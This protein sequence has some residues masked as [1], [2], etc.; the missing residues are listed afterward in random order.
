MSNMDDLPA[1]LGDLGKKYS[2]L[3]PLDFDTQSF[4]KQI[5]PQM[6][7]IEIDEESTF[8]YQMQQQTNQIIEKSNEQIKLLGQQNE[9]LASNYQKLEGLYALKEKE[10]EDAKQDAA[11]AK[12]SA[13][14][15]TIY[16]IVMLIIALAAWLL[17][18]PAE[19]IKVIGGWFS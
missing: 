11:K 13:K 3:P 8:A 9:Q 6:P 5:V 15:A 17:P 16:N 18:E 14:R 4:V 7:T 1:S 12:K 19:I 2:N 10:L